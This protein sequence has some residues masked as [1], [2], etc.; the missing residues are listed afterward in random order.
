MKRL[1]SCVALAACTLLVH[2]KAGAAA[3]GQ[4]GPDYWYHDYREAMDAAASQQAML[5]VYFRPS[6][7]SVAE[8]FES[9]VLTDPAV[10]RA[11]AEY[12][13]LQLDADAEITVKERPLRL[14]AH[15][16]FRDMKQ[17]PGVA[18][19]DLAHPDASYYGR[20]VSALAFAEDRC[21]SASQLAVVLGLPPGGTAQRWREYWRRVRRP[22][23]S[24]GDVAAVQPGENRPEAVQAETPKGT[25][26]GEQTEAAEPEEAPEV[27]WLDDYAAACAQAKAA[28]RMLFI[29]FYDPADTKRCRRFETETLGDKAVVRKL[30]DYVCA[31]LPVDAEIESDGKPLALLEHGA[32]QHMSGRPGVAILD[33]AHADA[34]YYGHV[35]SAFPLTERLWYSPSH[36]LVILDLPPAKLTQR[37]LIYAVRIHPERPASTAGT[38]DPYLL[39]EACEH[40]RHQ[41]R[42]RVQGHHRWERR[43]HRINSRLPAGLTASEVCAES[44]PGEGLVEAAIECVRS[45]RHSSGHWSAVSSYHPRYGYDIHRG[46]NGIWYATGIFGRG[47]VA[48]AVLAGEQGTKPVG[49]AVADAD[50]SRPEAAHG[51]PASLVGKGAPSQR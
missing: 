22:A 44:W 38:P 9:Q 32:F 35:V 24:P 34:P 3:D 27:T 43:F 49:P 21:Y 15:A 45:W 41:A 6:G 36:M 18:I 14:L 33:F 13:C 48:R 7:G 8:F 10:R 50:L 47:H 19:L 28:G 23:D 39:E 20:V 46:S 2:G 37:T 42:I 1:L 31:R 5:L 11:L 26:E 12:V 29:F 16:A 51:I 30:Q 17:K 4:T 25:R 40:S